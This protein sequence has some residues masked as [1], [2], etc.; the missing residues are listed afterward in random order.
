MDGIDTAKLREKWE[1]AR[2]DWFENSKEPDGAEAIMDIKIILNALDACR[3]ERD[4]ALLALEKACSGA[5]CLDLKCVESKEQHS[6]G[7]ADCV[8]HFLQQATA[9]ISERGI[10]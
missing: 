8:Q 2:V 6:C 9:E 5:R 4:E 1:K 10:S 3:K 7:V